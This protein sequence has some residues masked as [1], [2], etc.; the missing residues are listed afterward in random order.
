MEGWTSAGC[1]SLEEDCDWGLSGARL[2]VLVRGLFGFGLVDRAGCTACLLHVGRV[3]DVLK[4]FKKE[5][6][7]ESLFFDS[8]LVQIISAVT[9]PIFDPASASASVRPQ[10][11]GSGSQCQKTKRRIENSVS[12]K[13]T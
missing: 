5:C 11:R 1:R 7:L 6:F 8:I 4:R 9:T 10:L 2:A 13:I 12:S 3:E